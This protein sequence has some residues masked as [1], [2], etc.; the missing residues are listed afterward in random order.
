MTHIHASLL[1][2]AL[3]FSG[4]V[5][6]AF[7]MDR[8]H[9]QLTGKRQV[10]SSRSGLLRALGSA[11]L[12]AAIAPCVMGWGATVGIVVWIGFISAGALIGVAGIAAHVRGAAGAAGVV[13]VLALLAICVSASTRQVIA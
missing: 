12:V 10:P 3:S 11:L 1:A 13:G 8:H 7:A 5:A 2:L 6:L 4:M 9:E